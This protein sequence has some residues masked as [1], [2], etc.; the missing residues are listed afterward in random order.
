MY[1]KTH[2]FVYT[3][4]TSFTTYVYILLTDNME[5]VIIYHPQGDGEYQQTAR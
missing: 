4:S 5:G 2:T 1:F 3:T